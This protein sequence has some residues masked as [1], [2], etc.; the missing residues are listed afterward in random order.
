MKA[1]RRA[2]VLAISTVSKEEEEYI[3][4]IQLTVGINMAQATCKA[5][6]DI[7]SDVNIMSEAIYAH[8]VRTPLQPTTTSF[9]SFSNHET[10]CKG[11]VTVNL[12]VHGCQEQCEFYMAKF[13]ESKNELIL[14]RTWL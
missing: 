4:P 10:Q 7:G 9:A 14:G 12:H 2:Q 1:Q 13:K 11:M 6:L 3:P 8:L 5:I